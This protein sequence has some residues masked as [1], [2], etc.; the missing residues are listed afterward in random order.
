MLPAASL[1]VAPPRTVLA[2]RR[3][4]RA[5]SVPRD[6]VLVVGAALLTALLAQLRIDLPFTPVPITGQTLAVLL[7]GASLGAARG[8]LGQALYVGLG[9]VGLPVYAGAT[10]GWAVA[11]GP[12]LGYLVGFVLAAAAVGRLAELRHDR[13]MLTAIPAMLLGTAIVYACGAS[14][15][16]HDLGIPLATGA[17]NAVGLGVAPF[18]VGDAI[19]VA[20]AAAA[21]S[22]AWRLARRQPRGWWQATN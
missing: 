11:T 18:L 2:D 14:W 9:V 17:T 21:T 3:D 22:G 19:K 15:L 20:I 8:A 10:G 4:G 12:T 5:G 13:S 16:A 1:V 6:A 7:T